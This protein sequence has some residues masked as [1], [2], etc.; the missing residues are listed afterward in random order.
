MQLFVR[1]Q[2][3]HHVDRAVVVAHFMGSLVTRDFLLRDGT[4]TGPRS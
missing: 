3:W 4:R 2:Q 1:L